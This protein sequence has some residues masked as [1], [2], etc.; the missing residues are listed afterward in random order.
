MHYVAKWPYVSVYLIEASYDF[1]NQI[2]SCTGVF[3]AGQSEHKTE[4]LERPADFISN[5]GGFEIFCFN[6]HKKY[7]CR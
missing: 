2:G 5:P 3:M 1:N 6:F 7:R 4:N